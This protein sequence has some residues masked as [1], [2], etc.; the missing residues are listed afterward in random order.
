MSG[1]A[2][3]WPPQLTR[4]CSGGGGCSGVSGASA[5]HSQMA[6]LVWPPA[7][8]V[9]VMSYLTAHVSPVSSAAEMQRRPIERQYAWHEPYSWKLVT[10]TLHSPHVV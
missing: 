9:Q 7:L 6:S 2:T 1:K 10:S 4:C 3:C 8:S 5:E